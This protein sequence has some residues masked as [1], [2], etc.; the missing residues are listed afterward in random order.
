[1]IQ[2]LYT[3]GKLSNNREAA[4]R[5]VAASRA[6]QAQTKNEIALRVKELY[7]ALVMSRYRDRG[8]QRGGHV[9]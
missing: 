5:G 6:K 9:L 1:M 8:S 4:E 2:P 3:F 7:Y